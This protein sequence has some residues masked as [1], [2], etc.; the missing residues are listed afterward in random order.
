MKPRVADL[1]TLGDRP[2]PMRLYWDDEATAWVA[3]VTD[4]PGC[5]GVG[6]SPAEA[7]EVAQGF[8]D[9][10]IEDAVEAG[11]GVPAPSVRTQASGRFV[12]RVPRSLHGRLQRL[13][14]D[15]GI[16]L[17]QLV[18]SIL[19]EGVVGHQIERA[20]K[21]IVQSVQRGAS[22][23]ETSDINW[24]SWVKVSPLVSSV[25]DLRAAKIQ[26]VS[27]QEETV[28]LGDQSLVYPPLSWEHQNVS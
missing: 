18:V 11:E 19:S 3:E 12:A 10:W 5:V 27:L 24:G 14:A 4:L 20:A 21:E 8:I 16:S 2:Y 6:D 9:T 7:V 17:N 28:D 15:E 1:K 23:I 13:A 22:Q 26:V 25:M